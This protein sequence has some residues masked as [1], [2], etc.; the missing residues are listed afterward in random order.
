MPGSGGLVL[1]GPRCRLRRSPSRGETA[2]AP[3]RFPVLLDT[4][5]RH[6][7]G[8]AHTDHRPDGA[9][10][11]PSV[12]PQRSTGAHAL[13]ARRGAVLSAALYLAFL[14]AVPLLSRAVAGWPAAGHA[15]L[16]VL[17]TT[18]FIALA[19]GLV[20]TWSTLRLRFTW[21]AALA[22]LLGGVTVLARLPAATGWPLPWGAMARALHTLLTSQVPAQGLA[23]VL[24]D[25]VLVLA[26][27]FLGRV[28]SYLVREGKLLAPLAVVAAMV[29]IYTVFSGF[30]H[31]LLT[32]APEV[33][34]QLSASVPAAAGVAAPRLVTYTVGVGDFIFTAMFFTAIARFG[35]NR[36]A[37]WW[38]LFFVFLSVGAMWRLLGAVGVPIQAL[39]G[40]VFVALAVILAN[41][42]H[43]RYTRHEQLL[44]LTVSA[45]VATAIAVGLVV[46]RYL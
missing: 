28:L 21:D 34:R 4:E 29:D 6:R 12:P 32:S 46:T 41:W 10:T 2:R 24:G 23:Q 42:E 25:I 3:A 15:A 31:V 7:V 27:V 44:L 26:A 13:T 35:M 18:V 8:C 43:F 36:G 22:I 9:R 39:P 33:V 17:L 1:R 40:L 5:L 45:V 16:R 37:T 38:A 20:S 11:F 30:V 19:L 14:L